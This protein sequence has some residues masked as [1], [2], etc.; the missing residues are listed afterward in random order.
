[1]SANAAIAEDFGPQETGPRVRRV[2]VAEDS[3]IVHDLL[4]LLLIQRGHEVDIAMDGLQA[5]E[6]LRNKDYDVA[7]LDYHLPK[8]DGLEVAS[9]LKADSH[10]RRVPRLIAITADPEGLLSAN[11]GCESFDFILPKPLDINQVGRVIEEQAELADRASHRPAPAREVLGGATVAAV[12]TP[13]ILEGLRHKLLCWPDDIDSSRL[14]NRA[15]QATLGDTRFDAIVIKTPVEQD[16]LA[17]IWK[18]RALFALPVIDLTGHLANMADLDASRLDAH[19]TDKIDHLVR[20]FR[21]RRVR[22]HRDLL[23]SDDVEARLVGRMFV[24]GKPLAAKLDPVSRLCVSYN[25]TL[26]PNE[27]ESHA[28]GLYA[29]NLLDRNFVERF[30]VCTN[31]GSDHIHV[32]DGC[33]KCHS[34][35]LVE[36]EYLIHFRCGFQGPK[37]VFQN[38]LELVCPKCRRELEDPGVDYDRAAKMV[39][40]RSCGHA[41]ADPVVG[42]VCLDC[43]TYHDWGTCYTHDYFTY[44]LTDQGVGF[45][46]YGRSFLGLFQK[47]L[48]FEELPR[49]L[50]VAL[51]EAARKYNDAGT[52]FTLANIFYKNERSVTTDRGARQ[53]ADA[54]AQFLKNLRAALGGSPVVVQGPS[55]YDFALLPGVE[56]DQS[57]RDFPRLQQRA[58]ANLPFDIGATLKAFGPEDF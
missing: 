42:M 44:E 45:A 43:S 52:P 54:R 31:C 18:H 47:P 36:E 32:R 49:D 35:N 56:P 46:E 19:E 5:L 12:E 28:A 23:L 22:L 30:H 26:P 7:L 40:C 8:A 16:E 6:A 37:A 27:V 9:A 13:S 39:I 24:S 38:D 34:A 57:E 11:E 10:G 21:D 58:N 4:K 15:I 55:S 14:S 20:R 3:N 48:R 17:A 29:S 50:I 51:N 25:V 33:A 53:F 2:L 1:M 41:E